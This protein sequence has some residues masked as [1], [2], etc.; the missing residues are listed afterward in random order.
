MT[1]VL[2]SSDCPVNRPAQWWALSPL[3][4]HGHLLLPEGRHPKGVLKAR[5]RCDSRS[6]PHESAR[7]A[8]SFRCP[9]PFSPCAAR[10][11]TP[12]TVRQDTVPPVRKDVS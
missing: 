5:W 3:D 10:I 6:S 12:Q 4:L 9:T 2:D 7:T 8:T 11:P 1:E